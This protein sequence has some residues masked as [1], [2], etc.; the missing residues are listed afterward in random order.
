MLIRRR[1]FAEDAA[2][3]FAFIDLCRKRFDV[4]LMNPPFGDPSTE[5]KKYFKNNYPNAADNLYVGFY[6][7]AIE[8]APRGFVGAIT[9]HTFVTYR[10]FEG[11]RDSFLISKDH[12]IAL[13]DLGWGVL[14][15]AQVETA[16]MVLGGAELK[17]ELLGPNFRLLDTPLDKK[18]SA[19]LTD[20]KQP[21]SVNTYYVSRSL[22]SGVP[23]KPLCYWSGK[24]FLKLINESDPIYP[25]YAYAGSWGI[26]S[27]IFL[28]T[29]VGGFRPRVRKAIPAHFTGR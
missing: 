5:S 1:L 27:R 15:D 19:L 6:I 7:R 25:D 2:K 10:D 29:K 11:F 16:A 21:C 12:L 24:S 28:Q 13:C 3:G 17:R 23:G 20:V 14:D 4:V 8:M 9:S 22:I 26:T 18:E